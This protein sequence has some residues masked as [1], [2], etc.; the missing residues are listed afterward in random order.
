[1]ILD[2][3][4]ATAAQYLERVEVGWEGFAAA[5]IGAS[6]GFDNQRED[7]GGC[8]PPAHNQT[9]GRFERHVARRN[10]G[11]Y[12]DVLEGGYNHGVGGANVPAF[13]QGLARD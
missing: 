12:F 4:A 10:D 13:L 2:P 8:C 11:G 1:M 3:N 6:A 9:I 5:M 7:W